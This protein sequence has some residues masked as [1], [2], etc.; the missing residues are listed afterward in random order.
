MLIN[1]AAL[2]PEEVLKNI[3]EVV[4]TSSLAL[5]TVRQA[6][7]AFTV[8]TEALAPCQLLKPTS[9]TGPSSWAPPSPSTFLGHQN[10]MVGRQQTVGV[11]TCVCP[12][13]LVQN[14]H[15]HSQHVLREAE[16][17][18]S[19]RGWICGEGRG[20]WAKRAEDGG[21]R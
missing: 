5:S 11:N 14:C 21:L 17:L 9:Q 10:P 4:A 15:D 19:S 6:T 7:H 16:A 2:N 18:A 8:G 20:F 13:L 3:Q 12:F 1:F